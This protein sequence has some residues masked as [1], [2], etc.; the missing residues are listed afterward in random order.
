[1][2]NNNL[3]KYSPDNLNTEKSRFIKSDIKTLFPSPNYYAAEKKARDAWASSPKSYDNLLDLNI[4]T[5]IF[6]SANDAIEHIDKI[7]K[8]I[9]KLKHKSQV[10]VIYLNKSGHAIDWDQSGKLASIIN[11]ISPS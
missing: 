3:Y 8:I 1:V 11:T 4:S 5:T 10:S 9:S 7:Q 2:F 6:L